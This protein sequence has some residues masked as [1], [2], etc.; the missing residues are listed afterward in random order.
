MKLNQAAR[1]ATLVPVTL[2]SPAILEEYNEPITFYTW[3]RLPMRMYLEIAQLD[4]EDMQSMI[5]IV[6]QLALNEDGTAAITHDSSMSM[7]V[8]TEVIGSVVGLMG[9]SPAASTTGIT[10]TPKQ[11]LA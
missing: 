8:L 9:K 1:P 3:D 10:H 11:L 2:D 7:T 4:M 5:D 6:V